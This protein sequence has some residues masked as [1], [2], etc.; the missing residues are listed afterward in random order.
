MTKKIV[1]N[2]RLAGHI[3]LDP[4]LQGR[5]D[6]QG[7]LFETTIGYLNQYLDVYFHKHSQ[8]MPPTIAKMRQ[9]MNSLVLYEKALRLVD[10]ETVDV[11]DNKILKGLNAPTD[12]KK[13]LELLDETLLHAIER[14]KTDEYVLI[15][16]GWKNKSGGH[17]MIYQ[18]TKTKNGIQFSIYNSG[19]GIHFH[20][21]TSSR[22]N[23]RFYP[24]RSHQI[25]KNSDPTE[26]KTFIK[27]LLLPKLAKHQRSPEVI[28]E[29]QL[30][31]DID[32]S[33]GYLDAS[34]VLVQRLIP[35][36]L[37]T[38][39]QLSG[40]CAQRVLHQLLKIIFG[41]LAAYQQFIF[42]FKMHALREFIAENHAVFDAVSIEF[43]SLSIKHLAKLLKQPGVAEHLTAGK[44][45]LAELKALKQALPIHKSL[46]LKPP[47]HEPED[48]LNTPLI[49]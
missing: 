28:D 40:T 42:A 27:R 5:F 16:G 15:P 46:E 25:P 24:V 2:L 4:E 17:A 32:T 48:A 3:L 22:Q 12:L 44:D 39:S 23:E 43:I 7:N 36:E 30:Y 10:D 21:K 47:H 37:T 41:N 19:A 29:T 26:F 18:F 6:V 8:G 9:A 49:H 20:E 31:H 14:L 35:E 13:K 34:P 38:A 45:Y 1:M 11:A 33:L